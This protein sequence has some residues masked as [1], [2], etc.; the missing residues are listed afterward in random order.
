MPGHCSLFYPAS[1]PV[2]HDKVVALAQFFDERDKMDKIITFVGI[3]HDDE[4]ASCGFKASL[5]RVSISFLVHVDDDCTQRFCNF[6]RLVR[7]A[8]IRDNDFSVDLMAGKKCG[9]LCNTSSDRTRFIQAG[10]DNAQFN[11]V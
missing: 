1:E 7:T 4:F 9:G 2:S 8:V 6:N 3:C 10:Q 11:L 5:Q